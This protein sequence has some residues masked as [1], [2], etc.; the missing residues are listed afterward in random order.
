MKTNLIEQLKLKLFSSYLKNNL[1]FKIN[2]W[3]SSLQF[4]NQNGDKEYLKFNDFHFI[5]TLSKNTNNQLF[6]EIIHHLMNKK[7]LKIFD[8]DLKNFIFHC[9]NVENMEKIKTIMTLGI[10]KNL[11]SQQDFGK[12]AQFI[13]IFSQSLEFR[14][15]TPEHRNVII[16]FYNE[17]IPYFFENAMDSQLTFFYEFFYPQNL[18]QTSQYLQEQFTEAKRINNSSYVENFKKNAFMIYDL[19]S[20]QNH[21]QFSEYEFLIKSMN[22]KNLMN[23]RHEDF[24]EIFLYSHCFKVTYALMIFFMGN[25]SH[26][27]LRQLQEK[28]QNLLLFHHPEFMKLFSY[29]NMDCILKEKEHS[30]PIKI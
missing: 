20:T 24:M 2:F 28:T 8:I 26:A 6:K 14:H 3:K 9:L 12:Q 11:L 19:E 21:H 27:F 7:L 1:K 4:I 25:E 18:K 29:I 23:H 15:W 10:G 16:F 13:N 5:S 17:I 22:I 30:K